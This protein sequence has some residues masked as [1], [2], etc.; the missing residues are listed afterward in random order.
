[1]ELQDVKL[2]SIKWQDTDSKIDLMSDFD[3]YPEI[4]LII[5]S[6]DK[7]EYDTSIGVSRLFSDSY[8]VSR[9]SCDIRVKTTLHNSCGQISFTMLHPDCQ[10]LFKEGDRVRLYLNNKCRFCGFIFTRSFKQK[11]E[12]SVVAFDYLRYFKTPLSYDKSMMMSE[13]G[14]KGLT[15]SEIFTKLCQDLKLP[16]D[17]Y[18]N[19]TVVVPAQRYDMKSAFSIMEFAINQTIINSSEQRKQ[20]FTFFHESNL[21]DEEELKKTGGVVQLQL[22]NNLTT[23]VPITDSD[24]ITDY[25]YKTTIDSQTFNRIILYKDEKTYLSKTGK[26]LK[27]G[28]KTG[29]RIVR[30]APSTPEEIQKTSEGLYGYLPYYHK[31]PDSYTEAQMDKVAKD[32]LA[33][34]DRKTSSL[35]L[36]CYGVIGMRAGYLVPIA[37][38]Q[39]GG[40]SIGT[41]DDE[42]ST[43]IPI[44]RTVKE[45]ELIVEHPLKMN[46]VVSCG[47]QGEYD[48]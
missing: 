43:L 33:I 24:L 19:S 11:G 1:M 25:S 38:K 26:S 15:V 13:D 12:M 32:L 9:C 14:T 31:C 44:Y 23:N 30:I 17:V 8:D 7:T 42:N 18:T 27:K 4:Q 6:V 29:T 41:W 20:Y 28:K 21:D 36:S 10:S 22:R 40:T 16:F 46:L 39:I 2:A 48:L 47:E 3:L 45:C 5:D 35:T 37:I 34:L